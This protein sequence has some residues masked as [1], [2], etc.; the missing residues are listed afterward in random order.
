M[1]ATMEDLAI[2]QECSHWGHK[3]ARTAEGLREQIAGYREELKRIVDPETRKHLLESIVRCQEGATLNDAR[4]AVWYSE[5][6]NWAN[7][8]YR[9]EAAATEV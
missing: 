6:E 2:S 8:V 4:A 3:Y 5:S 7:G 1:K 9:E